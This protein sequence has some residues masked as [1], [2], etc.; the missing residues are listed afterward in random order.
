MKLQSILPSI[1][2]AAVASLSFGAHAED[3]E[4]KE[5]APA[6]NMMNRPHSHM[7]EKSGVA[8]KPK[9]GAPAADEKAEDAPKA[10]KNGKKKA[11]KDSHF[12]PRDGGK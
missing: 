8:A 2:F 4:K 11:Q 12:H 9:A 3:V 5:K 7:E 6:E 10:A 1:L